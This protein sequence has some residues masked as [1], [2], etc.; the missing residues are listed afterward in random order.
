VIAG[1]T[2]LTRYWKTTHTNPDVRS[3][4]DPPRFCRMI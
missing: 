2:G 1:R 4:K 3:A